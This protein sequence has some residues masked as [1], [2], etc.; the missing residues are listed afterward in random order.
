MVYASINLD[1]LRE[2]H[3]NSPV[4][5]PFQHQVDAFEALRK[6]FNENTTASGSGIL[7]LP[8]GAGKTFTAVRWLSEHVISKNIKVLWLAPSFYLLDQA[9]VSFYENARGI[10]EKKRQLNIR[11]V[12]SNPS[13]SKA[14][15]IRLTDDVIIMTTQTAINNLYTK[16]LDGRGD[17]VQT[18]FRQ[19]IDHCKETGL[20]VVVDE[21]HHAPAYG[22]RNLLIGT[23]TESPGLRQ[24][25]PDMKLLG[26]TATPTYTDKARRGWLWEIFQDKVIYEVDKNSLITQKIL[27][28]PNYIEMF[29]G[30]EWEVDDRLYDRLVK[31]HKDLPKE[32]INIL[33]RDR[34]RNNF[35]VDAYV[36]NK[37]IY[38]KTIIFVD[39]WFQCDYIKEKLLER[40]I[41]AEAIYSKDDSDPESVDASTKRKKDENQKILERFKTG[42]DENGNVAPLDVL[43]N[44]RMLTEGADVPSVKTVF[45]TRQTTSS[46]L[47]TQMIG[48]ALR[49]ERAGGSS[50][51]NIV[52]FFDDWKRLIDWA[53]PADGDMQDDEPRVRGYYP[54]EC[55]SIRLIEELAKSIE[56]GGE[57]EIP[58]FAKIFP[59]GWYKTEIVY[60]DPEEGQESMES[61]TEF[62]LA[63]EHTQSKIEGFM[64]SFLHSDMLDE[65]SK[66][67][68]DEGWMTDQ[69]Q[70]WIRDWFNSDIDDIGVKLESDL[71]KLARHIAQNQEIPPFHS[72]EERELY[73]LDRLAQQ[74]R[75]LPIEGV[76]LR[77][78][79][80]FSKPGMLWQTFYKS[81]TRFETAVHATIRAILDR[82]KYGAPPIV[83]PPI[84]KDDD[85]PF[86]PEE[87]RQIKKRDG[88]ACLCCG[89]SGKG[90]KLEIDHIVPV[91]TGGKSTL[92]NAQTL[93]SEC[94]GSSGKGIDE[95]N[96][97]YHVTQLRQPKAELNLKLPHSGREITR[98]I[99]RIVN[100]FYHCK[101]VSNFTW[102][103]R[104]NGRCYSVWEIELYAGNDPEWLIQHKEDL[105][106]FIRKE[107][108][109]PHVE[110]LNII[111]PNHD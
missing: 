38:G 60:A 22:C 54:Y 101:A 97:R 9:F 86:T 33:A 111:S 68:L 93:C 35:I 6:T 77:L 49:G 73:D 3:E 29:T 90:V 95:L 50:E 48:R 63:Y 16:A 8:T 19:F 109:S 31:K 17:P 108:H 71:I 4:K 15:S 72:F 23:K 11:C 34:Q 13:H 46:I 7:A 82:E 39:R 42:K 27:A 59:T 57:Y 74:A 80:E 26:L 1:E 64:D 107:L 104:R 5:T 98:S 2:L 65:W 52:L 51:A 66:E 78:E 87:K 18:A 30:K 58:P 75:H 12:S 28:R 37:H 21:A 89:A 47:M 25:L 76:R 92:E 106:E 20:F 79:H 55:I 67:Y 43:L 110:D 53:D 94:N 44:V 56:S 14:A 103:K 91:K 69:A 102:H 45:I 84:V 41:S 105:L 24:L 83:P 36:N 88:N 85:R 100:F 32:I 10:S 40:G 62:V 70:V 96:F 99:T 61:F 81:L